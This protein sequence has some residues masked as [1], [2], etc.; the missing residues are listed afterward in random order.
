MGPACPLLT[1]AMPPRR[2]LPKMCG[3]LLYNVKWGILHTFQSS[4]LFLLLSWLDVSHRFGRLIL[5][6]LYK[7]HEGGS[8]EACTM[9]VQ[10][11]K[12]C[13]QFLLVGHTSDC[14][15]ES[16]L[17]IPVATSSLLRHS[18]AKRSAFA[19]SVLSAPQCSFRITHI[20]DVLVFQSS[21]IQYGSAATSQTWEQDLQISYDNA[22]YPRHWCALY[23]KECTLRLLRFL[24]QPSPSNFGYG[25]QRERPQSYINKRTWQRL[26]RQQV[27]G[28][29]VCSYV[30]RQMKKSLEK[31]YTATSLG[32]NR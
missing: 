31:K 29:P 27:S 23:S 10:H 17:R 6:D 25:K 28:A 18:T 16:W 7:S 4:S 21:C 1:A 13:L 20:D 26:G 11:P 5:E 24:A 19:A 14:M 3:G 8:E 9:L 2:I 15:V 12:P 32:M 22:A 30:L